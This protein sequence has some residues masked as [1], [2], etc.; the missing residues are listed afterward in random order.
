VGHIP[1]NHDHRT[2]CGGKSFIARLYHKSE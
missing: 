2:R 1:W